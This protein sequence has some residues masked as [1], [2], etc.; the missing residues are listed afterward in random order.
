MLILFVTSS[1]GVRYTVSYTCIIIPLQII[2]IGHMHRMCAYRLH[3]YYIASFHAGP[4]IGIQRG[5][6]KI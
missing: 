4:L 1:F 3:Q 6:Y 2:N 5:S